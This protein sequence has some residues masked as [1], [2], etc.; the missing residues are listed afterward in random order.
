MPG[1]KDDETQKLKMKI[2]ALERE[3]LKLKN[4]KAVTRWLLNFKGEEA[5]I[6]VNR[7]NKIIDLNDQASFLISATRSEAID[8]DFYD[9]WVP[10]K[11]SDHY[12]DGTIEGVNDQGLYLNLKNKRTKKTVTACFY[13]MDDHYSVYS[14]DLTSKTRYSDIF[15]LAE[16]GIVFFDGSGIILDVN[17]YICNKLGIHRSEVAGKELDFFIPKNYRSRLPNSIE[18]LKQE[19]KLRTV[20]PLKYHG[21]VH[22]YECN[23]SVLGQ[24]LYMSIL[25]DVTDKRYL[26]KKLR[27]NEA[28]FM[29][30]FVEA[31][32]GIMLL[33]PEG[34]IL[35]ANEMAAEILECTHE[36]LLQVKLWEFADE[37]NYSCED[38]IRQVTETGV[39]QTTLMVRTRAGNGRH[40]EIKYKR[41]AL[42]QHDLVMIRDVSEKQKMEQTLRMSEQK[43]RRL[44]EGSIE[45]SVLWKDN[46]LIIDV[47]K[48]GMNKLEL[49]KNQIV[50]HLLGDLLRALQVDKS[51]LS[52][53]RKALSSQGK[54]NGTM[55]VILSG[56]PK[57]FEYST[58]QNVVDGLNFT[59]FR[60]IT[61]KLEMQEQL[62]KSD[63]LNILGELA[64][65]IAHEIRNPMT[66]LK[67][68]I[69]LLEGNMAEGHSMYFRI[70]N[71]ELQRIDSIINEFLLLAKPQAVKH[72]EV[73]MDRIMQ[74][75]VDL[76]NAQAVL[77]NVQIRTLFE[78]GVP[79]VFCE[80]NQLKKVFI[81]IIKNAIEVMPTGGI[82]TVSI[83]KN[84]DETIQIS[85]EDQ[86][87]GISEKMIKKLGEP[88][89]TTKEK[90]TGLGLMVSFKIIEE[91]GGTIKAESEQGVGTV[92]TITL[93]LTQKRGIK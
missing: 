83:S 25:R 45:G 77:H 18:L 30:L 88:F 71:T 80:P 73:G 47:N 17:P 61:E 55:K 9:F 14:I 51:D 74:E 42:D 26:E 20:L 67:G 70:I 66:S 75:T 35:N 7:Q 44:F 84:F 22:Y 79:R 3:N 5:L 86:G 72:M 33:G 65:G 16:D 56:R 23:T 27:R 81:N 59:V 41:N 31:K 78:K 6:I 62:R 21:N 89:Y 50:G 63:T 76:L 69:Q 85:I 4:S 10:L 58:K 37:S 36:E 15:H 87:I 68:F 49:T 1:V 19:G 48:A 39:A 54:V 53:I 57:F 11:A 28:L 92:F 13:A 93:P 91:H 90:G 38:V 64:A 43:F 24:G 46:G 8:R 60:N 82:V 32:D 12:L 52:L 34:A 29:D 40:L 2:A